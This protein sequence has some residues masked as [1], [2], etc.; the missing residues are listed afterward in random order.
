V[1][2]GQLSNALLRNCRFISAIGLH[3]GGMTLAQS[4]DLFMKEC[5]QDEG[6]AEQQAARRHLRPAYLNY[7]MN[8]LMI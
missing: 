8:K 1:H 4:K 3:T 7:T 6:N 5:Y 2:I